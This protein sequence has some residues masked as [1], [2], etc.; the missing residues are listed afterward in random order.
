MA[1]SFASKNSSLLKFRDRKIS[2]DTAS[3]S[4]SSSKGKKDD[5]PPTKKYLRDTGFNQM[6]NEIIISV[7]QMYMELDVRKRLQYYFILVV[8]GGILCD[9]LPG[10]VRTLLPFRTQKDNPLNQYF[11]K[12]GWAWTLVFLIPFQCLSRRSISNSSKWY[13]LRDLTRIGITTLI[14][15]CSIATFNYVE[16][17]TGKCNQLSIKSRRECLRKGWNWIGFDISGHTFLLLFANLILFEESRIINGFE[18]FGYLLDN[19]NQAARRKALDES[20]N[21]AKNENKNAN[22]NRNE[23]KTH[24]SPKNIDHYDLYHRLLLPVRVLYILMTLLAL[25]WDFML[26]QTVLNYH[27]LGQKLIAFVWSVG[28]WYFCYR[29]LFPANLFG[30]ISMPMRTPSEL[31]ED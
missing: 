21:E 5:S 25:L 17:S 30:L 8:I 19:K 14:W 18:N 2:M 13:D 28:A 20:R 10:L 12:L 6:I 31:K 11:V 29:A 22:R 15:Y 27:N 23:I 26:I 3:S 1:K 9:M 7:C 4:S 24:E 16:V